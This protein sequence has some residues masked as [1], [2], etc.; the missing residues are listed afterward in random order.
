MQIDD[1]SRFSTLSDPRI[2]PDGIKIALA[3]SRIDMS[4]DR[5]ERS[6]WLW[7]GTSARSF[8]SGH[9]DTS[10]RW[11]PDGGRLAFL[12]KGSG[13]DDKP[14]VAIIDTNGGEAKTVTDLPLGVEALEWAPDG[15]RLV[16]VASTW[17]EAWAD[18]DEDERTRRPR[19]MNRVPFRFDNRGWI[20]DRR[21]HL[22]LIDPEGTDAPRLLTPGDADE[23]A[24]NWRP[25][26]NAIVFLSNRHEQRGFEPGVEVCEVDVETGDVR[27]LV[28][29]GAW[30]CATYR[31]DATLHV[32]GQPD[33][34]SHPSI[35]SVWRREADG[36][37]TDLTGHLDRSAFP[38]SP[39]IRPSGPQWIGESFLTCVEDAGRIHVARVE[40]DGT[41]EEIAGGDRLI[42]GVSPT[43][44][45]TTF[46]FVATSPADPGEL[47]LWSKGEERVL[48]ELNA[49]FRA[50][51]NPIEPQHFT[52]VSDGVDIDT[53][54][55]LPEGDGPVPVLLNIHGGPATQYGFGFFDEFQMYAGAG[56][57]VVACNPRGS[58]GRGVE[59]VRAV[60]GDGW[61]TVD[62]S[63]V[64]AAL[65][66]SL[67]R[68]RR[69]D[70]DRLGVMGGSYG[71]FLAA[72]L[73]ERDHRY[74][75]AVVER[76]L[77][78]W[79]SF[80]GTSDIGATF[81]R[82]YLDAAPPDDRLWEA[83]PL[84]AANE[85]TT[86]TLLIQSENDYRC[87]I[88]QAE[89]FFMALLRNGVDTEFI[90]FP[91]EGHELSRSGKPR[92]RKERFE[93]ILD[94]HG[95]HLGANDVPD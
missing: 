10:P 78:S 87:P 64:T 42:T 3:T 74:R 47:F 24:P 40:P 38:H 35:S 69:L 37:L 92:H 80:S 94:W 15:S 11:S 76:A 52:T 67:E 95:R 59:F 27:R 36:S 93:F 8:T 34:W 49:G 81:G 48:T 12:R 53:W 14:Q 70:R 7:D 68:F 75:S 13:K 2:H 84:T 57:A 18:L 46:A 71:G 6:I 20:H 56:Y 23:T 77:L 1:L 72:W 91:G 61:G 39:A 65:E 26:G 66:A 79:T 60:T 86:P 62:T 31:P 17:I 9:G 50:E 58:S 89:Q 55:Y 5:Y 30:A 22:Y 51:A 88:E 28:D 29:R 19:R 45:G 43:A 82:H 25:D 83:S 54:V 41:I 44:D 63:D 4:E 32:V 90:R 21:S 33:P 16:A 73:I 85:V